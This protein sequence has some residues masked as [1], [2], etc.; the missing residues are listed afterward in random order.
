M[1]E[2]NLEILLKSATDLKKVN[3]SKMHAYVVAWIDPI[4]R[5]PGPIDKTNGS[6]PVWNSTI[7]VPLAARLLGQNLI[8]NL[9]L[10][11]LGFLSTKPIGSVKVDLADIM[12]Q[13]ASG[14]AVKVEFNNHQVTL[15][16][17]EPQGTL[18][19]EIHLTESKSLLAARAEEQSAAA[20]ETAT[21]EILETNL[22][23]P[24]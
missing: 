16:S 2:R 9:E 11:G 23:T 19:F 15:P 17:G 3:K 24:A 18:S 1:A 14:A 21:P 8:L 12:Q 22:A 13:G 5:V 7:T 20:Q 4:V 10:L 6:N